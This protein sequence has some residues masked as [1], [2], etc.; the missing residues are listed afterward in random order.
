MANQH[1]NMSSQLDRL[2]LKII[3]KEKLMKNKI[4]LPGIRFYR[5]RISKR[6]I[7]R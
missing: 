7:V 6:A 4:K 2:G 5:L 3:I 1:I